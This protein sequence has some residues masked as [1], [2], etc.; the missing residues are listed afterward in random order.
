[1]T[2]GQDSAQAQSDWSTGL[3]GISTNASSP[4]GDNGSDSNEVESSIKNI[5]KTDLNHHPIDETE[6]DYSVQE[7]SLFDL[8]KEYKGANETS[9]DT[10]MLV[11]TQ[12]QP[13]Q[14]LYKEAIIRE[15]QEFISTKLAIPLVKTNSSEY[16]QIKAKS[17]KRDSDFK[18]N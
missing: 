12:I 7:N 18:S 1:M 17:G 3:S 13:D 5:L 9:E 15:H 14:D 2:S 6:Y 10:P 4:Y 8:Y 11:Q 16:E